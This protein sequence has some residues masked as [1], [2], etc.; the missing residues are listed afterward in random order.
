ML[1][2]FSEVGEVEQQHQGKSICGPI[3]SVVRD[4]GLRAAWTT[5]ASGTTVV[6]RAFVYV[7]ELSTRV[8]VW[9]YTSINSTPTAF[10]P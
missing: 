1:P 10:S 4:D 7:P 8:P 9:Y 3:G 6:H 2:P 5:V